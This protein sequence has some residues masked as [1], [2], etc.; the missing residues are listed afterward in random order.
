MR[1]AGKAGWFSCL[2]A[3][4]AL[5]SDIEKALFITQQSEFHGIP[6]PLSLYRS[7]F[8]VLTVTLVR[9]SGLH[10]AYVPYVTL[11]LFSSPITAISVAGI[12]RQRR[13]T[14]KPAAMTNT[15]TDQLQNG[16]MAS[17]NQQFQL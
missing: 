4:V 13:E 15:T 7:Q 2:A 12:G 14:L 9:T 17:W 8:D 16:T 11:E 3:V 10:S 1:L 5:H 6:A